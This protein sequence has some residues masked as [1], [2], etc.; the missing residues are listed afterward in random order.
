MNN[1]KVGDTVKCL[2]GCGPDLITG[3]TYTITKIEEYIYLYFEKTGGWDYDR[4]EL[5]RSS[6][7]ESFIVREWAEWTADIVKRTSEQVKESFGDPNGYLDNISIED[8][9]HS[10]NLD[11]ENPAA[12]CKR[13]MFNNIYENYVFVKHHKDPTCYWYISSDDTTLIYKPKKP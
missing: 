6:N 4:F 1:F 10:P 12:F 5:V 3:D 11:P 2:N 7:E 8:L 9:I 13:H